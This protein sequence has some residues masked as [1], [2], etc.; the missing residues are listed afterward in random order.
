[1]RIGR[2]GSISPSGRINVNYGTDKT[3]TI[4]PQDGYDILDVQIDGVSMGKIDT[5]TFNNVT[6]NHRINALFVRIIQ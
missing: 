5:Y 3:F 6:T 1:T 4:V 2:G